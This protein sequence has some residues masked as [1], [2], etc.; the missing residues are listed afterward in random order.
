MAAATAPPAPLPITIQEFVKKNPLNTEEVLEEFEITSTPINAAIALGHDIVF[1]V[2]YSST[3]IEDHTQIGK[4]VTG[5]MKLNTFCDAKGIPF[6]FDM[7]K[8]VF[9]VKITFSIWL[10]EKSMPFSSSIK[11][12]LDMFAEQSHNVVALV[13][14]TL[15]Y[16]N[17]EISRFSILERAFDYQ[18]Y[19]L[20]PVISSKSVILTKAL[21]P[22]VQ[23]FTPSPIPS[24]VQIPEDI[25]VQNDPSEDGQYRHQGRLR[26]QRYLYGTGAPPVSVEAIYNDKPPE[27]PPVRVQSWVR[28][29]ANGEK[30]IEI[31]GEK[32]VIPLTDRYR[33]YLS[34][35]MTNHPTAKGKKVD[36]PEVIAFMREELGNHFTD[37]NRYDWTRIVLNQPFPD[38]NPPMK[39]A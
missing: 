10:K 20:P 3:P 17:I 23:T 37:W 18:S 26:H 8:V 6:F 38:E 35:V 15:A 5:I 22:T 33:R 13:A 11:E 14:L 19:G 27:K 36:D 1:D 25:G 9:G 29:N 4:N 30:G 16:D 2:T 31:N 39:S 24:L 12:I 28:F 21:N 34:F 32:T 7:A